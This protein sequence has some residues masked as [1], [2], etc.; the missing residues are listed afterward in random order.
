[1]ASNSLRICWG[2]KVRGSK[3]LKCGKE[4]SDP[5]IINEIMRL[6]NEFLRRVEKHKN[7]LLNDLTTPFDYAINTLGDWLSRVIVITNSDRDAEELRVAEHEVGRKILKF[8]EELK[9]MWFKHLQ[10]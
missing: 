2:I 10:A 5:A 6:I 4:V 7:V 9:Q 3:R 8:T 1:M